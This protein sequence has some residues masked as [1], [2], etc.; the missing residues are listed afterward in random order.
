[1]RKTFIRPSAHPIG[2]EQEDI[3][4]ASEW[5]IGGDI[6]DDQGVKKEMDEIGEGDET[7]NTDS[8]RPPY[9]VWDTVWQIQYIKANKNWALIDMNLRSLLLNF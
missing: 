4:A 2:L 1:M 3:I 8:I 7:E 5:V 6:I 9:N